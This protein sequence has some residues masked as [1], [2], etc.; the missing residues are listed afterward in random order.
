MVSILDNGFREKDLLKICH[1][2]HKITNKSTK[3]SGNSP[4][5]TNFV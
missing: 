3:N 2:I 4:I 1:M 5:L